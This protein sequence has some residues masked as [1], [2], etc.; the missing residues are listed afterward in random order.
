MGIPV[1]PVTTNTTAVL[2]RNRPERPNARRIVRA[3]AK[4]FGWQ[5]IDF[6]TLDIYRRDTTTIHITWSSDY[7]CTGTGRIIDGKISENI[8]S[9]MSIVRC[10][11]WLRGST[12]LLGSARR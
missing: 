12:D 1:T 3:D 8:V 7:T 11:Q 9:P 4:E 10:R 5:H 6:G 2:V